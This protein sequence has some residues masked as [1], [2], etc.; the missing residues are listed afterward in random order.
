VRKIMNYRGILAGVV[1]AAA[2]GTTACSA[3][4]GTAGGAPASSSPAA[5]G[6]TNSGSGSSTSGG[7]PGQ[8]PGVPEAA[9]PASFK[10]V[11]LH[12]TNRVLD[13]VSPTGNVLCLVFYRVPGSRDGVACQTTKPPAAVTLNPD[14]TYTMCDP[15][16][17]SQPGADPQPCVTGA[18]PGTPTLAYGTD[19]G[20]GPFLCWSENTGVS[21]TANGKGIK[22]STSGVVPV[23]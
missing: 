7:S 6:S 22:I 14:G 2:V 15:N 12:Q 19:T 10:R 13:F 23:G 8:S 3:S 18:P 5:A 1:L 21:C 9:P 11:A 4:P 20:A 17:S 16:A